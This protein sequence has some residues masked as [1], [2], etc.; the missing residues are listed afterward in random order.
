VITERRFKIPD[1]FKAFTESSVV[2]GKQ[3]MH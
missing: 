3:I 1:K 2:S